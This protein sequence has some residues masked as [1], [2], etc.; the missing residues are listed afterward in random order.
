MNDRA[1]NFYCEHCDSALDT[2]DVS[3]YIAYQVGADGI[4]VAESEPQDPVY[5]CPVCGIDSCS[6]DTFDG[7][8]Q[9]Q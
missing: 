8:A 6:I 1:P 7:G 2:L 4:P 5:E 9:P 3:A